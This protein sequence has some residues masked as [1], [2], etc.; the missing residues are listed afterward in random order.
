MYHMSDHDVK[1]LK[2]WER[3]ADS[4][5]WRAKEIGSREGVDKRSRRN[6][7]VTLSRRTH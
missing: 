1:G 6:R 4:L 7:R 5:S 3:P 2:N